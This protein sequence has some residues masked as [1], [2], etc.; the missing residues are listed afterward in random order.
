MGR[1]KQITPILLTSIVQK[2]VN[3]VIEEDDAKAE[4]EIALYSLLAWQ[5]W[6]RSSVGSMERQSRSAVLQNSLDCRLLNLFKHH[7]VNRYIETTWFLISMYHFCVFLYQLTFFL[8]KKPKKKKNRFKSLATWVQNSVAHTDFVALENF[9]ILL[10]ASASSSRVRITVI[11][12][13]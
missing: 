6:I 1:Q 12:A 9:F 3:L 2:N 7:T 4:K 8:I 11:S 5:A 10:C 13:S